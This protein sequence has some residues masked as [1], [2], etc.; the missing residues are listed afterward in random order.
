VIPYVAD[1]FD[2]LTGKV[3]PSQ[4]HDLERRVSRAQEAV[5]DVPEERP[6]VER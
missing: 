1:E 5:R 3:K 2:V 4:R 6:L